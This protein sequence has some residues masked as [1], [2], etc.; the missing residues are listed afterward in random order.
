MICCGI[1]LLMALN[2]VAQARNRSITNDELVHIPAGYQYLVNRRFALNPEHPPLVKL[3]SALPLLL[4]RPKVESAREPVDP[5]FGVRTTGAAVRF[6]ST[7]LPAARSIAFWA[8][9]PIVLITIG[10]GWLIFVYARQIFGSRAAVF[11]VALFSLE[12][13]MLAHGWI[14][15]TDVAAALAYLLFVFAAESY[16]RSRSISSALFFACSI[17]IA[18]ITKFSLLIVIPLAIITVG[19]DVMRQTSY[20]RTLWVRPYLLV[21]VPIFLINAIYFGRVKLDRQTADW[22]V[23]LAPIRISIDHAVALIN[24]I[25]KVIPSTYL[26]GIFT[27][28]LH[29]RNGHPASI[30][31]SYSSSGWWYYFPVTFGLKTS[32]PFLLISISAIGW[33]FFALIRQRQIRLVIPLIALAVYLGMSMTSRI[34]IGIRH[35]A[36]VFPFLFILSGGFMDSWLRRRRRLLGVTGVFLL[37]GWMVA[38]A[39][40]TYPHYPSFTNAKIM[41]KENW[42]VLSDSNIEWGQDIG[43]LANYLH[44]RGETQLVGSLSAGWATPSVHGINLLDFAPRELTNSPTRYVAIGASFLNGSTV[45]TI[46]SPTKSELSEDERRNYFDVYR[47]I[48]PEAI[49]GDSIYLYRAKE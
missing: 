2:L 19:V 30:L 41:G 23:Q 29:N 10:L 5:D 25:S 38:I 13:T 31:G 39:I 22:M 6:W 12:P 27:V 44:A 20:G 32:L 40:W 7:N 34:D 48:K 45:S 24:V 42:Q 17:G 1:L 9:I 43:E 28:Y 35:V 3:L 21:L 47:H 8:R 14:V 36:P 18:L 16:L 15:H 4:T 37:F 26:F 46:V 33:S 11:A 49:F